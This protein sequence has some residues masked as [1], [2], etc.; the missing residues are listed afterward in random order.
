M[1]K[2]TQQLIKLSVPVIRGR[3]LG[4]NAYRG[5]AKLCDLADISKADIYD[6]NSN[7]LGTQRDLSVS[8]AKDAYEYVKSK[9]L[10]FWPEVFL[11]ARKRNVITF[12]PISDENP[13]IGILELDVREIF[14]SPEIAISR[15][16]GNH[17]L[18]FANGREKGYSKI[19]KIASFCLAYELSREDEIQLFKDIN[20]NQKPMNTSHLDGI[21]VR[22]TPEEY[23]KRRDPELYIA[24]KLGDDDKSVFHNR[25]F[26]GGK[27]GSAVDLPLRSVKTGIEYMLSRSTQLPRLEDAEAKYRVIRNYFA[28]FKSWQPKSWS[29]PKEY[30]TLRGA[31]FWAVCFIGAHVIDRALIQG[32]FDE[33]SMLKI[34]SSGKEWDWSKSGDFKGYSGRGG[35]LEI[36]KQVSSKLHDEERMSTK[37]LFASIMSI[38]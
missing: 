23:L 5:F 33:E 15:I 6:Q 36:S 12:T 13:E 14:T 11:C 34:L 18:H 4:V 26:K 7:P 30:I 8:H 10:G 35:A 19:E 31:G 38:D 25:V 21:E 1:E 9:E 22:L 27:K 2:E 17:R 24:Q 3:V 37:E 20:K 32:K 29:N 28:A 16:D